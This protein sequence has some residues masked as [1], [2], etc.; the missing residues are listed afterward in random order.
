VELIIGIFVF[1]EEFEWIV[2]VE[3]C[4]PVLEPRILV[5]ENPKIVKISAKPSSVTTDV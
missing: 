3:D 2:G 5:S 4:L 1:V